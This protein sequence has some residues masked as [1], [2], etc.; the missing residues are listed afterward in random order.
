[1]NPVE[2]SLI[3]AG[4]MTLLNLQWGYWP[5]KNYLEVIHAILANL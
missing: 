5:E 3:L 1:M 2:G 4:K